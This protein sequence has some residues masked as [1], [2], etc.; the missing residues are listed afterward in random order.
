MRARA[1]KKDK[2]AL[3]A[4]RNK[5]QRKYENLLK[6]VNSGVKV[7]AGSDSTGYGNSTRLIRALEMM[8]EAGMTPMQVIQSA[9]STAAKALKIDEW[10]GSIQPGVEADII[11][12]SGNPAIDL[13]FLRKTRLVM[14]SGVIV[15]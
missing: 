1:S 10:L 4:L 8:H 14:K 11:G 6:M 2:E 15:N 12:V 13:G 5:Y 7:V 9:T 3:E